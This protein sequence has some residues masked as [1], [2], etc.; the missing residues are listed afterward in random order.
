MRRF[1]YDIEYNPVAVSLGVLLLWM[2][3]LPPNVVGAEVKSIDIQY[4]DK[5]YSLSSELYID[6]PTAAVFGVLTDYDQFA[7]LTTAITEA[8]I[9]DHPE[10]RVYIVYTKVTACILF[11]CPQKEKTE[12]IELRSNTE[13]FAAIIPEQSDFRFGTTRWVLQPKQGGTRL[14]LDVVIQPDFWIPPLIGPPLVKHAMRKPAIDSA[15][16]VERLAREVVIREPQ[17][18]TP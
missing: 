2:S 17:R 9:L 5:R 11:W 12:R 16:T 10:P 3:F 8:R 18:L 13:V 15:F 1:R 7:R 14:L 4:R 6:A